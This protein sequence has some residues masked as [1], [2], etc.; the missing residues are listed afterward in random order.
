MTTSAYEIAT[1]S[2]VHRYAIE[3]WPQLSPFV[4]G[5]RSDP[6]NAFALT[7]DT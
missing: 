2:G 6:K 5:T 3:H 1:V 7:S 4:E